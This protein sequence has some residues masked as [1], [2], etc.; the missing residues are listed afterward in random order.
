M[1][2]G[3]QTKILHVAA[4]LT[5]CATTTEP[6]DPEPVLHKKHHCNEKPTHHN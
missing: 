4:Q 3:P 1:I 2:P 6:T 5:L